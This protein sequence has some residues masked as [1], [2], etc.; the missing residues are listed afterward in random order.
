MHSVATEPIL[1]DG[2]DR[3]ASINCEHDSYGHCTR[4]RTESPAAEEALTLV[5]AGAD[6]AGAEFELRVTD[7]CI[8]HIITIEE[9]ARS[10]RYN[11]TGSV[12]PVVV[13]LE[14]DLVL[15]S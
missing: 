7:R 3:D 4:K 15:R 14:I 6:F 10:I 1:G 2:P 8:S 9:S 11:V 5:V 12:S 13:L